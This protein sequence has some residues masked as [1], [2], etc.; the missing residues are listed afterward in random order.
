MYTDDLPGIFR[1]SYFPSSSARESEVLDLS[2]RALYQLT[3]TLF[4]EVQA[5]NMAL[6]ITTSP[7]L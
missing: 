5:F 7:L 4:H 2:D 1:D 6:E 3:S